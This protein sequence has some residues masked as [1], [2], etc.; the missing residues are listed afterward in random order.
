MGGV[1]KMLRSMDNQT[2]IPDRVI[3]N[4]PD[5]VERLSTGPL[6]I[7]AVVEDWKKRYSWLSVHQTKDFGPATKLLGTLQLETDPD[8]IIVVLDDDTYY[9]HDTILVLVSSML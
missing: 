3:I 8:T 9:H 4:F 2:W 6:A 1:E 5:R 7:P